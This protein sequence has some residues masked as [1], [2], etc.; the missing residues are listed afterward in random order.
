MHPRTVSVQRQERVHIITENWSR[1]AWREREEEGGE[2]MGSRKE[3]KT[4]AST[5]DDNFRMSDSATLPRS[6]D[7]ISRGRQRKRE[8][9]NER[10]GHRA[11]G[12]WQAPPCISFLPF[13]LIIITTGNRPHWCLFTYGVSCL[14]SLFLF[15]QQVLLP[16]SVSKHA[17]HIILVQD[18]FH[19]IW[20]GCFPFS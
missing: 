3:N 20:I 9:E 5:L 4:R 11:P 12:W 13:L 10:G 15:M 6:K 19:W 1:K 8:T 16:Q 18:G 14:G 7:P 2:V 17:T